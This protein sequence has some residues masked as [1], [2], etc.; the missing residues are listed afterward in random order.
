MCKLKRETLSVDLAVVG[1]GLAGICASLSAARRGLTTVLVQDRPVL[2]G[3][4]SSEVRLWALGA[5]AHMGN[6]NRWSREG[7]IIDELLTENLYRNPEGNPVIFDTVLLDIVQSE[8]NIRLLLNTAMDACTMVGEG[9]ISSIRAFNSQNETEYMITAPFFCDCTGDG[10][11]GYLAGADYVVGS[12]EEE[13]KT[14][15]LQYPEKFGELLGSTIFFYTRDTG[16][17]VQYI[18]PSYALKDISQLKRIDRISANAHGCD[19]WWIEWAGTRNTI[20]DSEEIKFAL[21]GIVHGI[22]NHIKNSG[23]FPEAENLTLEWVGTIPGKRESRRFVGDYILTQSDVVRQIRHNDDVSFGGWALDHHPSDGAFSDFQPCYQ[24]HPKGVYPIPFRT[25]YSR[26]IGNL[27][28]GGRLISTSRAAFGSTRVM[29]TCAHNGQVLGA[30]AALCKAQ[31]TTPKVLSQTPSLIHNLQQELLRTGQYIPGIPAV[32]PAYNKALD[33]AVRATSECRFSGFPPDG[34][35]YPLEHAVALLLPAPKGPVPSFVLWFQTDTPRL[36]KIKIRCSERPYNFTPD[37]TLETIP[38][39]IPAGESQWTFRPTIVLDSNLYIFICIEGASGVGI[40]RSH[41]II[42]GITS[43][44]N[45]SNGR[46]AKDPIQTPPPG[47]GI[48]SF[49]FWIPQRRP[50]SQ[51][52]AITFSNPLPIFPASHILNGLHRPICQ[53]NIWVPDQDDENPRITLTWS[54]PQTLSHLV[55]YFDTDHD[56]AMESVQMHHADRIVPFCIPSWKVYDGR[57][58]VLYECEE[59][60]QGRIQIAISTCTDVLEIEISSPR[61]ARGGVF[62]VICW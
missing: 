19:Y 53:S 40:R 62:G 46:V 42:S 34:D 35:W 4:A 29:M 61:K 47:S 1:G 32:D 5:T 59:N 18:P 26:N 27:L 45:K 30:A 7:G 2:G 52:I 11:L 28:L 22:W 57:G 20:Y 25:M 49:A 10:T 6:N 43:V 13:D 17:S 36:V 33:A 39:K 14:D 60:H 3:N 12:S 44:Y 37:I 31:N 55:L 23:Q 41:T 54:S 56:F 8:K 50:R 16:A 48:D 9:C 51:N 38:A 24:W 58:K 21:W 15:K